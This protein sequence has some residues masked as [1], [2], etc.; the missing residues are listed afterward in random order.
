[1][2]EAKYNASGANIQVQ[3]LPVNITL[4][5]MI[6]YHSECQ[7]NTMATGRSKLR[8]LLHPYDANF[9]IEQS[10]SNPGLLGYGKPGLFLFYITSNKLRATVH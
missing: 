2:I 7:S 6:P 10:L 5:L 8:C 1:M 4:Y 9:L 3:S